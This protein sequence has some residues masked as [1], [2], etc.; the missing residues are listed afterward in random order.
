MNSTWGIFADGQLGASLVEGIDHADMRAR[1]AL[2]GRPGSSTG[3]GPTLLQD[4][5]VL[6]ACSHTR[7]QV[8]E[9][10]RQGAH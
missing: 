2:I 7:E 1:A 4:C 8:P 9:P 10:R 3:F 6:Q 5:G